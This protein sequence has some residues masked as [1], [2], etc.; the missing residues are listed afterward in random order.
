MIFRDILELF[1]HLCYFH[2]I[3]FTIIIYLHISE[4]WRLSL[5]RKLFL[6]MATELRPNTRYQLP[7]WFTNNYSI[8]T[9]SERQQDASTECR[10]E[11]RHL[12]NE[13]YAQSKWDQYSNNIR[14]ADRIDQIRKWKEILE[15]TLEGLD[16]E[17][18]DLSEAKNT[19]EQQLEDMN[20]STDVNVE[21]LTIR[22]GR[23]G[24][25]IVD[26]EPDKELK[27][28]SDCHISIRIISQSVNNYYYFLFDKYR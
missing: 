12:R 1:Q 5:S 26:D 24:T 3:D 7:D 16:K 8:S 25:D 9:N 22:E 23:Q 27:K 18:E 19:T 13:T 11:G 2:I 21:N 14:L 17:I 20:L 4:N 6:I 15:R 28:V 10:Q